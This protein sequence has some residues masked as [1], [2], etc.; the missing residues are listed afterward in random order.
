MIREDCGARTLGPLVRTKRSHCLVTPRA[1][2]F[3]ARAHRTTAG[4]TVLSMNCAP[5]AASRQSAAN[6]TPASMRGDPAQHPRPGR[7]EAV[8]QRQGI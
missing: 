5:V 4:A 1:H 2:G 3:G 7:V 8:P 6:P